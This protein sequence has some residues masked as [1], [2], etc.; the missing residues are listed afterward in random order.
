MPIK[1]LTKNCPCGSKS[2]SYETETGETI[3]P[4]YNLLFS[5]KVKKKFVNQVKK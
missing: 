4:T 5:G 2:E 3:I 1:N